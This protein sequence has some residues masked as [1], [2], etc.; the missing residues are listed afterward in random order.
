MFGKSTG[1]GTMFTHRIVSCT[2]FLSLILAVNGRLRAI[3]GKLS[4][5]MAVP[6]TK[7]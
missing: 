7:K 5:L 2:A 4:L 3:D 6:L 1:P